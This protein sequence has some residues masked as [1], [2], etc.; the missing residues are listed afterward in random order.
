[1]YL[2][3]VYNYFENTS[4][5]FFFISFFVVVIGVILPLLIY[6]WDCHIFLT[7]D[8]QNAFMPSDFS[9]TNKIHIE[10]NKQ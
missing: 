6:S 1:M 8:E 9:S 10:A 3:Q 5:I 2:L 7:D 4:D